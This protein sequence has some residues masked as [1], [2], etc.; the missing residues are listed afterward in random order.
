MTAKEISFAEN[1][2]CT[3]N[4]TEAAKAA[5]YSERSARQI[6]CE[7]LTKPYIQAYIKNKSQASL[8]KL[9]ITQ[10]RVLKELANI[11]FSN[12]TDF[13]ED[14]WALKKLTDIPKSKSAG[15][16]T[17]KKTQTGVMVN[18]HDRLGALL[19]L[20]E[21]VKDEQDRK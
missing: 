21:L 5:G 14:D 20:W 15:I 1:Y 6:G 11:A 13:F 9:E 12:V 2:L 3:F 8:E 4:A 16:K 7:N 19:K 10:E 17:L 18:M